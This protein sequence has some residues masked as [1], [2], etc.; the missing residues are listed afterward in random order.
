MTRGS[1]ADA[2]GEPRPQALR[3]LTVPRGGND[4]DADEP[5]DDVDD[6]PDDDDDDE[7]RAA[8]AAQRWTRRAFEAAQ[9]GRPRAAAHA[10]EKALELTPDDAPYRA[11]LLINAGS[12]LAFSGRS[13]DALGP[14]KE[15]ARLAPDDARA[16]HALGTPCTSATRRATRWRS[17]RELY[18]RR[19]LRTFPPNAPLLNNVATI[20][21]ARGERSLA[22]GALE[23]S[24]E[25]EPHAPGTL[26]NL[27]T[28]RYS[29]ALE[30]RSRKET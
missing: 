18:T 26:F 21:L 24:L 29:D 23:K 19:R 14:L 4:D 2:D 3:A 20:L 12:Y 5:Y 30:T 28:A 8:K 27:A 15:A 11:A 7:A 17:T 9:R 16:L 25:I 6:E 10:F 1:G 22:R 13:A